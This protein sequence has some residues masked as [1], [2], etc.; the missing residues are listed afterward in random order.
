MIQQYVGFRVYHDAM[1]ENRDSEPDDKWPVV[2]G[3]AQDHLR[4]GPSHHRRHHL[5]KLGAEKRASTATQ[6][7]KTTTQVA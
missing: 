2:L 3:L 4:Q 1:V 7:M 6:K 5:G